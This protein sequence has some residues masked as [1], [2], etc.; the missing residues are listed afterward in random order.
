MYTFVTPTEK[1]HH[2]LATFRINNALFMQNF[3]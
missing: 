2:I 1:K 3:K